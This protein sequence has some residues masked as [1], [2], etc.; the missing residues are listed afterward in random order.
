LEAL[1]DLYTD[2]LLSS[3]SQVSATI[4]SKVLDNNISHD[5][6]TRLLSS[7]KLSSRY[8]WQTAK[9]LCKEI[10]SDFACLILDDS[11]EAK[12]YS[13]CNSLISYHFDHTVGKSVKGV[14]FLTALFYSK[15]VSVPVGVEF[16][17]KDEAYTKGGKIK[18]KSSASKNELY[19]GLIAK[20]SEQL[21]FR[22]I[23]NDSWFCNSEN[24]EFIHS[25]TQ[26][27]FVMAMKE[28]RRIALSLEDKKAG[29]YISIKEAVIEG[30]VLSVYVEQLDFPILITKQVFKNGDGSTGTLYLCS[31]D[32]SLTYE[33]IITIYKKRWKVEEYHKST[34]SNCSFPKS[35]TSSIVAQKSHFIA[36][37]L[38][39]IKMERLKIK[40]NKNH[41]ALKTLIAISATKASMKTIAKLKSG[42]TKIVYK[43]A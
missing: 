26:S 8:L 33:Q 7:G 43:A 21:R 38:A 30:C 17:I 19:R 36:C 39:F 18:Y 10:A 35:P 9:P 34:K 41:F 3:T 31:N 12:P 1:V 37:L 23:L 42:K 14:N 16:I 25:E 5:K 13:Q 29:K 20:A 11:V 28:N 4:L 27:Y 2:Y 40:H 22:Y 24:M 6:F 32:L 15:E